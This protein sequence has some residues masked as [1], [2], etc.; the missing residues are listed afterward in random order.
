[1]NLNSLM[2]KIPTILEIVWSFLYEKMHY[3]KCVQNFKS[4]LCVV[5]MNN[6]IL[7]HLEFNNITTFFIKMSTIL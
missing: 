6:F 7:I 3:D 4:P 5:N 2:T 1:M